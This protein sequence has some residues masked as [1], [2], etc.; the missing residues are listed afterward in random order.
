MHTFLQG[1]TI[2]IVDI[3][4]LIEKTRSGELHWEPND[5]ISR[6]EGFPFTEEGYPV[7][8]NL[9]E[10]ICGI[11]LGFNPRD[12]QWHYLRIENSA[13]QYFYVDRGESGSLHELV[14][15][16]YQ[17]VQKAMR[18][19]GDFAN[20]QIHMCSRCKCATPHKMLCNRPHGLAGAIMAGSER[21]VCVVCEKS[22]SLVV[23]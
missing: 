15:Q 21:N 10:N 23:S 16:L 14:E 22:T 9:A 6:F 19:G 20:T 2:T 3:T 4:F 8:T 13:G 17:G 7:W 18:F 12:S 1:D 11:L 5:R